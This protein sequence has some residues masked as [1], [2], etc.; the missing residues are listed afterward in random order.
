MI[1][2][3]FNY[4][5]NIGMEK[6]ICFISSKESNFNEYIDNY[7]AY[8]LIK[9][10]GDT[11]KVYEYTGSTKVLEASKFDDMEII[12]EAENNDKKSFKNI[13]SIK[14]H[15]NAMRQITCMLESSFIY[16][17]ILNSPLMVTFAGFLESN[18]LPVITIPNE[19]SIRSIISNLY[20]NIFKNIIY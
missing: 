16:V 15:D 8:Y 13:L 19:N 4:M 18:G 2:T 3:D 1:N 6:R 5:K 14:S 11:I 10:L 7:N 17:V 20:E 9:N 12:V